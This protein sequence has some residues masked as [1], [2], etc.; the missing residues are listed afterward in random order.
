MRTEARPPDSDIGGG[1]GGNGR[2]GRTVSLAGSLVLVVLVSWAAAA[3]T[4]KRHRRG[5]AGRNPSGRRHEKLILQKLE[6][7]SN[8][9]G[10]AKLFTAGGSLTALV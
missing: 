6:N 7:A 1:G 8:L 9:I 3:A 10:L 2:G 4:A 5:R